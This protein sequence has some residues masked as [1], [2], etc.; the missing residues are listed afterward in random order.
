MMKRERPDLTRAVRE[1]GGFN[2]LAHPSELPESA[3]SHRLDAFIRHVGEVLSWTW[4]LLLAVIVLNVTLRYAFGA[5]RIE[6]EEAQWHLYSLGFLTGLAYCVQSDTHIRVD[7]LRER[8]SLRTQAWIELYGIVLLALPFVMLVTCFALPFVATAFS[9]GEVSPSPGGLQLR[10]LIKAAL[11]LGFI[12]L[13]ISLLAR[14]LRVAC[15][16]FGAPRP[17]QEHAD[18]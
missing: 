16:L 12:L 17:L 2:D 5:G 18:G 4:L 10:W 9:S 13:T 14:L 3:L 6:L 11:P 8:L 1:L 15:Y 7:V